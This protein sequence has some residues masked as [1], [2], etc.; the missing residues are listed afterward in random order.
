MA[1]AVGIAVIVACAAWWTLYRGSDAD[2]QSAPS[3]TTNENGCDAIGAQS[4]ELNRQVVDA[5]NRFCI[6]ISEPSEVT[7]GAA[8]VESSASIALELFDS[9]DHLLASAQSAPSKDPQI[10]QVLEP[11]AYLGLVTSSTEPAPEILVFTAVYSAPAVQP[12]PGD[13]SADVASIGLPNRAECGTFDTPWLTAPVRM[14][15]TDAAP[16]AC[17]TITEDSWVKLGLDSTVEG[18]GGP[19]LRLSVF[20]YGPEGEASLLRSVD[21]SFGFDP[22]MSIDLAP[23]DYLLEAGA[24]NEATIGEPVLYV[25]T[26]Q[27]YF[28]HGA[29]SPQS[30]NV[31]AARCEDAVQQWHA[32]QDDGEQ[33]MQGN[34]IVPVFEPD[35]TLT[36]LIDLGT[37]CLEVPTAQRLTLET[38]TLAAQDLSLEVLAFEAEGTAYRFAWTDENPYSDVLGETDPLLDLTFPAGIYTVQVSTY[39][40][41]PAANYDVR[42]VPSTPRP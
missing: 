7:V 28:R 24:W 26:Q 20:R 30:A 38:A 40:G 39:Y 36:V 1:G 33:T 21:D 9:S 15:R 11:G 35:T 18:T 13:D 2:A 4:I 16:R 10:T 6:V 32:A 22:E 12:S 37:L 3:A 19:D 14:T 42:F 8:S 23:G 41:D 25:D 27:T 34:D 17:L 31:T 5:P 29:P